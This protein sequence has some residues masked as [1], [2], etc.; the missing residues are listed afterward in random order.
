MPNAVLTF[1]QGTIYIDFQQPSVALTLQIWKPRP[2]EVDLLGQGHTARTWYSWA[3][4]YD[5]FPGCLEFQ[6]GSR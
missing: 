1:F 4:T 2:R 5:A 6:G 3:V